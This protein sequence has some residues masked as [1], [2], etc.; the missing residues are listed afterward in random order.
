MERVLVRRN[1]LKFCYDLNKKDLLCPCKV[2]GR[3]SD[4]V[5]I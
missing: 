5:G 2:H 4:D 1:I 3:T